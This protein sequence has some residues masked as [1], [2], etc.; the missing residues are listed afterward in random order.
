[1]QFVEENNYMPARD[2]IAEL[3]YVNA[4]LGGLLRQLSY[5]RQKM[6]NYEA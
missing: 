1:M 4:E 5:V 2:E 3:G 6:N